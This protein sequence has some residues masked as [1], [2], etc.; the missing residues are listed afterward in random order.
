MPKHVQ[1]TNTSCWEVSVH[2][3]EGNGAWY[4]WQSN[5]IP[6]ETEGA[7][8]WFAGR[9][10]TGQRGTKSSEM[11]ADFLQSAL[12]QEKRS[13]IRTLEILGGPDLTHTTCISPGHPAVDGQ[14]I[15][16]RGKE[17]SWLEKKGS[18]FIF[19]S[20]N[21]YFNLKLIISALDTI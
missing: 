8:S 3:G 19:Q 9:L 15:P 7:E 13:Q 5:M 2:T 10:R 20:L 21:L 18:L 17:R 14:L 4:H 11:T 6:M 12:T 1:L 16:G